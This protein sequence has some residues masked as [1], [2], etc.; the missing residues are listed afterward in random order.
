MSNRL[1][2]V[3][4]VLLG[5]AVSPVSAQQ[6]RNPPNYGPGYRPLL[7]PYLNLANTTGANGQL[8]NPAINYYLGTVTEFDRRRNDAVFR[9]AINELDRRYMSA[10]T[11]PEDEDLLRPLPSSGH[12][13]AFGNTAGYFGTGYP[14]LGNVGAATSRA[15]TQQQPQRRR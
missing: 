6:G 2:I 8:L 13:T 7:S 4:L 1:G 3:A 11:T 5:V 9:G 12:M 15:P 14:R 10:G